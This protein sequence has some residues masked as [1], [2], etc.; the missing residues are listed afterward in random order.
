[1]K[2]SKA[3]LKRIIRKTLNESEIYPRPQHPMIAQGTEDNCL[4]LLARAVEAC[5][6]KGMSMDDICEACE[7]ECLNQTMRDQF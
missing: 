1:M 2:I 7:E 5:L 4:A 6:A 3:Q